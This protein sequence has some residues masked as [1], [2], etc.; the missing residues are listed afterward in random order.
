MDEKKAKRKRFLTL[1][2][3]DFDSGKE[4]T[5]IALLATR[6]IRS[7]E[8]WGKSSKEFMKNYPMQKK[9]Q[10]PKTLRRKDAANCRVK[11]VLATWE[12]LSTKSGKG[13]EHGDDFMLKR[14]DKK[15]TSSS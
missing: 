3:F 7:M 15:I 10:N 8:K 4:D 1:K 9:N 11:R 14:E 5:D 6:I 2:A 12:Y 13:K